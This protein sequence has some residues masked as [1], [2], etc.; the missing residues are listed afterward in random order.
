MAATAVGFALLGKGDNCESRS[1]PL[2]VLNSKPETVL[3][4]KLRE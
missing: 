3:S 1:V 4:R 2:V